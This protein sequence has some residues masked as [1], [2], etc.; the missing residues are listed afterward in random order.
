[1]TGTKLEISRPDPSFDDIV[2]IPVLGEL[3]AENMQ[4]N[5]FGRVYRNWEATPGSTDVGNVS[6]YVPT[7]YTEIAL[8]DGLLF[9][10]HNKEA[11]KYANSEHA[12]KKLHQMVKSFAGVI[13]DIFEKPEIVETAKSQLKEQ[14]EMM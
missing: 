5:G 7:L 9:K 13:I 1:M 12:Y 3:A 4:R 14:K 8:D 10:V 11:L 2:T 6:N